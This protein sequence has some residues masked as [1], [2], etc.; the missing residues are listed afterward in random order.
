M[1]QDRFSAILWG[2]TTR[3][4]RRL[5]SCLVLWVQLFVD[6]IVFANKR[7]FCPFSCK[8]L[9]FVWFE[10]K[11]SKIDVVVLIDRILVTRED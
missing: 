6:F 11:A 5:I 8:L 1:E 4:H 2:V 7:L 3:I 9:G 10:N